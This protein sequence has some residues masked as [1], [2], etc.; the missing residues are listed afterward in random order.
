MKRK[1]VLLRAD[2]IVAHAA[3]DSVTQVGSPAKRSA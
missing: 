1:L 3:D 2:G